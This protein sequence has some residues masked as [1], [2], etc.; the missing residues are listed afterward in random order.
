MSVPIFPAELLQPTRSGFERGLGDARVWMPTEAALPKPV[1]AAS[2]TAQEVALVLDLTRDQAARFDRFWGEETRRGSL[3]F[4]MQDP[5]LDGH[6][7]GTA[8]GAPLQDAEG[9]P[10]L[11]SAWWLCLFGRAAPRE[12][13]VGIRYQRA[14]SL[15]VLP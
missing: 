7:L 10:I 15:M 4:V 11:I 13:I 8:D 6:P 3:P 5:T 2:L 9:R 14:V 12:R 1:R